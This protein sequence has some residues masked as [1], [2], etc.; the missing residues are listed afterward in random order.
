[1]ASLYTLKRNRNKKEIQ[2][3]KKLYRHG[4]SGSKLGKEAELKQVLAESLAPSHPEDACIEYR[5][6]QDSNNP[7]VFFL[8]EN[9]KSKELH[10]QQFQKT[11]HSCINPKNSTLTHQ[12]KSRIS[13][14]DEIQAQ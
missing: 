1:M 6:H 10:Q 4:Y 7:A 11:I 5:L 9:W 12:T 3:H 8:Y 13:A 14:D 2:W